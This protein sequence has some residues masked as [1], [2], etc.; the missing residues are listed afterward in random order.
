M[1]NKFTLIEPVNVM[2]RMRDLK[3][4]WHLLA[5]EL[6]DIAGW[7]TSI[8]KILAFPLY[9]ACGDGSVQIHSSTLKSDN[10]ARKGKT[11]KVFAF[12]IF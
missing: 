11:A 3:A 10:M 6:I 8:L 7:L 12:H 1:L 4:G 5:S 9:F 2:S